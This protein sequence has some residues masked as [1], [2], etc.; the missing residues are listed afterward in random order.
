MTYTYLER[1]LTLASLAFTLKPCLEYLN[2]FL[3]HLRTVCKS[4]IANV[5]LLTNTI[6]NKMMETESRSVATFLKMCF[7]SDYHQINYAVKQ[8]NV[9]QYIS[10]PWLHSTIY[11]KRANNPNCQQL[12]LGPHIKQ[13]WWSYISSHMQTIPKK[14]LLLVSFPCLFCWHDSSLVCIML[15]KPPSSP[16]CFLNSLSGQR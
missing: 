10:L 9:S 5:Q 16:K 3:E 14:I 8:M 12:C 2:T 11:H 13:T 15:G 1:R 7:I 6:T 4:M